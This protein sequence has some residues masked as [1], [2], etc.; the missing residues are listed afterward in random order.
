M[1]TTA[2]RNERSERGRTE[3]PRA[4]EPRPGAAGR[5]GPPALALHLWQRV[6]MLAAI[7]VIPLLGSLW[8]WWQFSYGQAHFRK[9]IGQEWL[10]ACAVVVIGCL[11]IASSCWLVMPVARWLRDFPSWHVRHGSWPLW[12]LPAVAGW[13]SFLVLY[14][15]AALTV[16][17]SL[18]MIAAAFWHLVH[19]MS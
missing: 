14:L 2:E 10:W 13:L 3:H 15:V 17:G 4:G 18:V 5:G 1:A 12:L 8:L 16:M 6:G 19:A 9:P 11:I 7:N